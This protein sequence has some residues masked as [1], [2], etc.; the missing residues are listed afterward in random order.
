MLVVVKHRHPKRTGVVVPCTVV[1]DVKLKSL[2]FGTSG[3]ALSAP[4]ARFSV[5][6][7]VATGTLHDSC[8]V[9]CYLI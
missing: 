2:E 8:T 1:C 7:I 9:Y 6:E 5:I 3:C 4:A